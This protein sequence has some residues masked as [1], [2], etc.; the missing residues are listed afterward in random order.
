M[1][2]VQPGFRKDV[3]AVGCS[4]WSSSEAAGERKSEVYPLGYVEGFHEPRTKLGIIFSIRRE[5]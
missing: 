3:S 4:K 5:N 2:L 1:S